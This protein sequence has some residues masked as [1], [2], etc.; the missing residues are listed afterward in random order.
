MINSVT[1]PFFRTFAGE[2]KIPVPDIRAL[3]AFCR[4]RKQTGV[5]RLISNSGEVLYILIKNGNVINSYAISSQTQKPAPSEST[6]E[7]WVD[8]LPEAHAKFIPLSPQGLLVCKLLIQNTVGEGKICTQPAEISEYLETQEKA[9]GISLVQLE[10]EKSAGAVFFSNPVDPPYSLFIAQDS[11]QDQLGIAPA[12]LSPD[13]QCTATTFGF[14]PSIDAWQEYLLRRV[15]ADIYERTFARFQLMTGRAL[16]DSLVRLTIAIAS[17]RHLDISISKYKVIDAEVFSSPQAAADNY[18][19]LLT[20]MLGHFSG[21]TGS[22][23][24][25]STLRETVANLSDQERDI[26][27][28][29]SLLTEGYVYERKR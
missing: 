23:L 22:R 8:T 14:D 1:A 2:I 16:V 26:I 25:S 12:I 24:L 18:R 10:W 4:E 28:A 15:F 11:L 20:E 19:M 9:P 17:R 21:I 7:V 3:V 27:S 5:I 29:F 6:W 13:P